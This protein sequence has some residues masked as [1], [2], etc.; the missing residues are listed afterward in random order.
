MIVKEIKS[1]MESMKEIH[2]LEQKQKANQKI[3]K[4]DRDFRDNVEEIVRI[5]YALEYCKKQLGFLVSL[6][7]KNKLYSLIK[8]CSE[9]ASRSTIS[10]ANIKQVA[11]ELPKLKQN[12]LTEWGNYFHAIADQHINMLNTIKGVVPD[13]NK[14]VYAV[15]KINGGKFWD[16]KQERIDLIDKGLKEAD[17]IIKDLALTDEVTAFFVKVVG[18]TAT[19]DDLSAEVLTWIN[20]KKISQKIKISFS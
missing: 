15:N 18:G 9:A 1:C 10:E 16:F 17:S 4:L 7:I 19:I 8:S 2:D 5:V 13:A 14:V 20:E 11:Q 3:E 6:E 12:V